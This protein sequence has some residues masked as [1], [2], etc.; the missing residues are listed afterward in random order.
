MTRRK[1]LRPKLVTAALLAASLTLMGCSNGSGKEATGEE[2]IVL[3]FPTWQANEPGNSDVFKAVIAEFESRNPNAKINMYHV[4]NDDF[5]AM[6]LTQLQAETPPDII[7][8]G[9]NQYAPFVATGLMEPLGERLKSSGLL[10]EWGPGQD[11]R[12][13]DGEYYALELHGLIRM[14]HY[15]EDFLSQAGIQAPPETMT[16]LKDAVAAIN[17][18]GLPDVKGWGATTTTHPNLTG[19]LNAFVLGNGGAFVRDGK[20][21]VTSPET[22]EAVEVYRELGKSAAPGLNGA[23][24]RQLMAE[25]KVGIAHDG[26]WVVAFFDENAPAET[27]D[28]LKVAQSPFQNPVMLNGTGLGIAKDISDER[29]ELAWEFIQIAAEPEFQALWAKELNAPPGRLG[30]ISDQDIEADEVLKAVDAASK[31]AISEWPDSE[32]YVAN[33]GEID[34]AIQDAVMRMLTSNDPTIDI[35]TDLEKQLEAITTP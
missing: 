25:N 31:I 8:A 15:N 23:Q 27:R 9:S 28:S 21:A 26:N 18:L 1:Y 30:A 12:L 13:V 3:Q 16:D 2:E 29:K 5:I 10:D 19:E 4:P 33:F 24:Y 7:A 35:L 14:L 6:I 11:A 22:V 17:A 34:L 20:W 32:N